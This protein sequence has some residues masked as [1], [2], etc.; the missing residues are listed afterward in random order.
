ASRQLAYKG[1]FVINI[2]TGDID[3]PIT[4][5]S[6]VGTIS[7]TPISPTPPSCPY[8]YIDD[9]HITVDVLGEVRLFIKQ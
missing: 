4:D 8:T 7:W 3:L 6:G 2:A 1:T 5:I 9:T